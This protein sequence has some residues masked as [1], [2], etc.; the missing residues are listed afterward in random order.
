[1]T[2]SHIVTE[3]VLGED[4]RVGFNWLTGSELVLRL[5]AELVLLARFQVLHHVVVLAAWNRA[6][7]LLPEVRSIFTF[8]DDVSW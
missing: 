2:R 7:H 8:L 1:M 6:R 5:D 4:G 3:W